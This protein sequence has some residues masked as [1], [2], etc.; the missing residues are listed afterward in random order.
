MGRKNIT[1]TRRG[2]DSENAILLSM[3]ARRA[4]DEMAS[5]CSSRMDSNEEQRRGMEPEPELVVSA[6]R[7]MLSS[8]TA[9]GAG[10][11]RYTIEHPVK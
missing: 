7:R 6:R 1:S 4:T 5:I 11:G 3:K 10:Q 8:K 2:V 9:M